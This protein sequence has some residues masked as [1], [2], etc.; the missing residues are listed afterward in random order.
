[1]NDREAC[2]AMPNMEMRQSQRLEQKQKLVLTQKIQQSLEMLQLPSLDLEKLIQQELEENPLLETAQDEGQTEAGSDA[3]EEAEGI[4]EEPERDDSEEEDPLDIL[5]QIEENEGYGSGGGGGSYSDDEEPWRPEP[6][7]EPTLYEHLLEQVYNRRLSPEM[8]EAA[9]YV[10]YSL[11]RHGLLS[12]SDEELQAGWDGAPD[13]LWRAVD[14]V[15]D[16]EP[17]GVGSRSASEALLEQ[18]EAEGMDPESLEYRMV[19]DHFEDMVERRLPAIA[20]A[21]GVTPHRVQE[22]MDSISHLDPWP[23]SDFA[24]SS[25]SV[26]IP[27]II[28]REIDG[29]LRAFLND[30]R[31]PTLHISARNRRILESP[32]TPQK[33]KEYVKNK[34]KRASWFIKAIAQRQETMQKIGTFLADYQEDFFR[35]GISGLRP[36]TLQQVADA[37]DYNQS[38]I[39]RAING[40]YIQSPRGVHEM[41]FLFSRGL[42]EGADQMST[43]TVKEELRKLIASEDKQKPYS[44]ARLAEMLRARGMDV[45]RR[46]VANYRND[47]GIESARKRRVY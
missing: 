41:R 12:L 16:L 26:V 28:I 34:F 3:E 40:K 35:Q 10:V 30:T 27:D 17:T 45:K 11:D 14:L 36:L 2:N 18:L 7:K 43:R 29:E 6:V 4:D 24:G 13:L 31:F 8:E 15:G 38:T 20:R 23:G 1:M 42:G 32:N 46:T 5:K 25:N 21:E 47:L 9:T 37:L 19:R 22:A 33:E 44:D 39:S